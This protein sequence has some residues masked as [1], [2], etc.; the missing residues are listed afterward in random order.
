[1]STVPPP[2]TLLFHY[3]RACKK[4]GTKQF[5]VR[6]KAF[7]MLCDLRLA[8]GSLCSQN[9]KC[10]KSLTFIKIRLKLNCY[11]NRIKS[12]LKWRSGK[13]RA[14]WFVRQG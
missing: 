6:L 4:C 9:G 12:R 2:P 7:I 13:V 14:N 8:V 10:T 11:S 5:D 3:S 1:M